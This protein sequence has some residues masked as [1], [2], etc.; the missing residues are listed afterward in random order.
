MR[1]G[2]GARG[3]RG[4]GLVCEERAGLCGEG[5]GRLARACRV[6]RRGAGCRLAACSGADGGWRLS[7][8]GDGVH[9]VTTRRP[10]KWRRTLS[11]K[12]RSVRATELRATTALR[13]RPYPAPPLA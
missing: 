1:R 7:G 8:L 5:P 6:R 2:G 9:T 12:P 4:E 10:R 13:V 11:N 3:A